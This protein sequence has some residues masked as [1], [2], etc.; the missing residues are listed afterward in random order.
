MC[1]LYASMT[2]QRALID[3]VRN[4]FKDRTGNLPPLPGIFPDTMAPV[5]RNGAD[6]R[7]LIMARWGMSGPPQYGGM[8]ITNIR[9][10]ASPHWRRW[11]GVGNRCVVPFT[12]FCEYAPTTPRK[13]PTWF[14]LG[15]DR[16]LAFFAGIWGTWHGTRGSK[17]NPVEGEH[18][19]Y[20]FLTTD[21]NAE[22]AP[23]H[24]KAMPVILTSADEVE[25]WLT[26]PT[27]E[28]MQ[29]QRP[30]PDGTLKIVAT[31]ERSDDGSSAI[32][33]LSPAS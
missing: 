14:A 23:V 4:P 8:P 10:V 22:V 33:A 2:G 18:T 6:G 9:N 31:G 13:T 19:L 12:S 1:N 15:E 7:E 29:L 17:A 32:G 5:L 26:L 27:T 3:F 21:A 16:P 30:L 28:A 24:P 20:G 25:A 11:L